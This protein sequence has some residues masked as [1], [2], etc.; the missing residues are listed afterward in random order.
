MKDGYKFTPESKPYVAVTK[1]MTNQNYTASKITFIISGSTGMVPGV[2]IKGLP[3]RTVLS[4]KSG[5]YSA[6]VNYGWSGIVTPTKNGYDF[7]PLNIQYDNVLG[8]QTNQIYTPTLQKRTISGQI[9]SQKGKP[10]ADV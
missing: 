9:L 5:T 4:D 2:T 1:D 7:D 6:P 3:G 8:D 10:V